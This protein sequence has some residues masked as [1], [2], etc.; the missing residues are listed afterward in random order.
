[1]RLVFVAFAVLALFLAP[2]AYA[3]VYGFSRHLI[4]APFLAVVLA[5]RE[6]SRSVRVLLASVA[7]AFSLAGLLMIAGE[8]RP[9]IGS[10]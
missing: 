9:L 2:R 6:D 8:L 4:A 5:A 3:D 1:V 10:F 7:A